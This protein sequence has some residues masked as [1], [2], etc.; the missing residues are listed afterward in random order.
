MKKCWNSQIDE[1]ENVNEDK[2]LPAPMLRG[3]AVKR[4]SSQ[5]FTADPNVEKSLKRFSTKFEFFT[6][7]NFQDIAVQR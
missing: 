6:S 1:T 5:I 7:S 2:I 4:H 3:L